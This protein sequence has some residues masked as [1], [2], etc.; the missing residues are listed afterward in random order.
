M[1]RFQRRFKSCHSKPP[2]SEWKRFPIHWAAD[3]GNLEIMQILVNK[4]ADINT[5]NGNNMTPLRIAFHKD[6]R[7]M[8]DYLIQLVGRE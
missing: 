5:R 3:N 1:R 4:G 7:K 8:I 6:N 2:N